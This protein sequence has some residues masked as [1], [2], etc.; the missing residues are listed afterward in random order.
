MQMGTSSREWMPPEVTGEVMEHM[1]W[2]RQASAIFRRVCKGWRDT[3]DQCVRRLSVNARLSVDAPRFNVALMLSRSILRFQ[4]VHEIEVRD[5]PLRFTGAAVV[6]SS[7]DKLFGAL[8]GLTALTRLDLKQCRK[9]SN[10]GLQ[11]LASPTALTNLNL[12]GCS[13]VSDDGLWAL[14]G[15]T[16]LTTLNLGYCQVSDDGLRALVGLTA[17]ADLVLCGCHRVSDD[18]L[19]ALSGFTALTNLNLCVC[20][21]VSEDGL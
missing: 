8:A 9:V 11:A 4:R 14:A 18:G 20:D 15:L 12:C 17:L 10:N 6:G 16:A 1:K 3:H 19:R 21:Q 2:E 13:R 7:T 5:D